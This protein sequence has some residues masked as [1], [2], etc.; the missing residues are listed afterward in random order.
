MTNLVEKVAK[1]SAEFI[2]KHLG[3]SSGNMLL[4]TTILG[5]TFSAIAQIF[6]IMNNNKYT[7]SQ[8]AFMVPQEIGEYLVTASSLFLITFPTQKLTKKMVESGKI[9]SKDTIKYLKNNNLHK[10]IG[11][12]D[13]NI[14]QEIKDVINKIEIS[15]KFIKSNTYDK[16]R[17]LSEHKLALDNYHLTAD[18]ASAIATTAASIATTAIAVPLIRNNFASRMQ[19]PNVNMYNSRKIMSSSTTI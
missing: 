7:T 3:Q 17:I 9:I 15:D 13:F 10:N 19:Q 8:K 2:Y 14:E 1:N 6:A 12:I 18:A 16:E 11:K 4:A 5:Y